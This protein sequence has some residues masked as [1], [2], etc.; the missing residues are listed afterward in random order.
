[1]NT[2]LQGCPQIKVV[3]IL[4]YPLSFFT[5]SV[6]VLVKLMVTTVK[7]TMNI[8]LYNNCHNNLLSNLANNYF[9]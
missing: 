9:T 4:L 7:T 5:F 3:V 2:N 8:T 6:S 1:M